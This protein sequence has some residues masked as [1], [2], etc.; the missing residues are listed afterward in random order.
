[1][2]WTKTGRDSSRKMEQPE[3][4]IM[5]QSDKDAQVFVSSCQVR[6]SGLSV[7]ERRREME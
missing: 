2:G 4:N 5:G 1:M 3:A 6:G 7:R